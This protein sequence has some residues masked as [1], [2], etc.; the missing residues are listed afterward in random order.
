M[1]RTY[2]EAMQIGL[3]RMRRAVSL[4]FALDFGT[5]EY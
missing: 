5:S 4:S 1:D 2:A 3:E